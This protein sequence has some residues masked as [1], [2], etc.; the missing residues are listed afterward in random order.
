MRSAYRQGVMTG[1]IG[2]MLTLILVEVFWFPALIFAA[3]VL[4]II[5]G[6]LLLAD[7]E[8]VKG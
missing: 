6:F 4:S 2:G 3:G 5:L 7:R 1:I 8:L